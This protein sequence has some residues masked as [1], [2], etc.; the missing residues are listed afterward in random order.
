MEYLGSLSLNNILLK[1]TRGHLEE[2]LHY[3][4][5]NNTAVKRLCTFIYLTAYDMFFYY[6]CLQS[7]M[8]TCPCNV[9]PI[10]PVLIQL[11]LG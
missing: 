8:K 1:G 3:H 10:T 5:T 9:D 6:N 11:T 4:E 2:H 7:I